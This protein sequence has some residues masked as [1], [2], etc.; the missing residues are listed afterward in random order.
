[1]PKI[2]TIGTGSSS[3][4]RLTNVHFFSGTVYMQ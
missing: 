3:Y 4:R 1:M 2:T